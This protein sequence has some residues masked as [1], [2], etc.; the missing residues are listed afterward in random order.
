MPTPIPEVPAIRELGRTAVRRSASRL[1]SHRNPGIEICLIHSG[2][3]RWQ[4]EGRGWE[5]EGGQGFVTLPW[6]LHGGEHGVL[7]RGALE[8]IVIGLPRCAPQGA[9]R[10]G[11][12]VPLDRDAR[13]YVTERLRGNRVPVLA[14]AGALAA[15]FARLWGELHRRDPGWRSLLR[16]T[17]AELLVGAARATG[18][19]A[20]P[21]AD[22]VVGTALA[23]I[24]E[25]LDEPWQL[26]DMAASAGMAR[27]RFA[28]RVRD[29]TGLS[30]HRWLLRTRLERAQELLA[31]RR[32]SI[33]AIALDCGFASSQH[34]AAAFKREFG[35]TPSSWRASSDAERQEAWKPK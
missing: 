5:V 18:I 11:A 13:R 32:A 20:A 27:T 17:L 30:P 3:F 9:W 21:A 28:E 2:R 31:T 34:F 7:H 4:V 6:Q 15:P 23:L 25:R 19:D 35:C 1:P 16:T 10:F 33:T 8:F 24:A 29:A 22:P 14:D 12:D 26:A